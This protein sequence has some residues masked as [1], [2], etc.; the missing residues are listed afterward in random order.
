MEEVTVNGGVHVYP[1]VAPEW[2][3]LQIAGLFRPL[4][5]HLAE[6]LELLVIDY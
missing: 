3:E 2:R 6:L 1:A 5:E 4:N